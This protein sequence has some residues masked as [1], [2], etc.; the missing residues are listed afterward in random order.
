MP[1]APATA[2]SND[3]YEAR[4]DM[5]TMQKAEQIKNDPKRI[6]RAKDYAARTAA[7]L[8]KFAGGDEA[9]AAEQSLMKGYRTPK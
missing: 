1:H 7:E 5:E 8:A 9:K 6:A 3:D 4:Y 2:Y